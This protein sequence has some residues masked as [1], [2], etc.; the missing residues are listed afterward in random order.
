MGTGS[1]WRSPDFAQDGKFYLNFSEWRGP[2]QTIF[3]AESQDLL[4]WTRL[5]K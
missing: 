2:R 3:F 1:T 5:G 4:S